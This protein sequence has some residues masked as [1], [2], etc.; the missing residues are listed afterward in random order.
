[1]ISMNKSS[2]ENLSSGMKW[3]KKVQDMIVKM[4]SIKK[5]QTEVVVE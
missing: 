1:M 3:E 5:T 4:K 2:N